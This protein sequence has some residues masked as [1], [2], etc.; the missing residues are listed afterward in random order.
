MVLSYGVSLP[1]IPLC[2]KYIVV[3]QFSLPNNHP[4]YQMKA[5]IYKTGGIIRHVLHVCNGKWSFAMISEWS[6]I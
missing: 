2:Y 1:Y 4:V 6:Y 5:V 3:I